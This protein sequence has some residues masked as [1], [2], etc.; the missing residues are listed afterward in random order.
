MTVKGRI[1][2]TNVNFLVDTGAS[3]SLISNTVYRKINAAEDQ[4][5]GKLTDRKFQLAD[6]RPLAAQGKLKVNIQL[7]PVVVT[8]EIIVANISDEGIIG[9]DFLKAHECRIDIGKS[10]FQLKGKKIPCK[11]PR[12]PTVCTKSSSQINEIQ[13]PS[14]SI[15]GNT[16]RILKIKQT[17]EIM[18]ECEQLIEVTFDKEVKTENQYV[19]AEPLLKFEQKYGM[20]VAATMLDPSKE[21]VVIRVLN[22]SKETC[23]NC[24]WQ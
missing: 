10:E 11:V 15:Q 23:N 3:C 21:Q 13:G 2:E 6:G 12:N 16:D 5:L 24:L 8:H 9:Y 19:L 1:G 22:P 4:Q 7:G 20:K 14:P 18:P 17:V